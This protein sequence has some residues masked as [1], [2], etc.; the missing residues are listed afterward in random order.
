MR[1][2]SFRRAAVVGS[3]LV[4]LVGCGGNG[5]PPGTDAGIA[6]VDAGHGSDAGGNDAGLF[7]GTDTCAGLMT[8]WSLTLTESDFSSEAAYNAYR[9]L[10]KCACVNTTTGSTPSGCADVCTEPAD[11]GT[12]PDFCNGAA[13]LSQCSSC[14]TTNCTVQSLVCREN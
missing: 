1:A 4:M 2:V 13:A 12:A 9:S 5:A 3:A 6:P 11:G 14:L 7:T 10:T 8:S